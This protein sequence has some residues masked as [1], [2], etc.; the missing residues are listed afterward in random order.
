MTGLYVFLGILFAFWLVGMIAARIHIVYDGAF[1]LY[2]TLL[3]IIKIRIM[4]SDKDLLS[5]PD[6]SPKR[7]ERIRKKLAKAKIKKK[8]KLKKKKAKKKAKEELERKKKLEQEN[9]PRK[10]KPEEKP[11]GKKKLTLKEI[12]YI[13]KLVARVLKIFLWRFKKYL[14]IKA[15]KIRIK[16]ASDDAAKTAYMHGA[17]VAALRTLIAVLEETVNFE[18]VRNKNIGVDVD[19]LSEKL[20]ADIHIVLR[21]RVWHLLALV[22]GAVFT[23]IGYYIKHPMGG[24]AK[25]GHKVGKKQKPK[26]KPRAKAQKK[27]NNE[28][29]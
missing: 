6:L 27:S 23:A 19:F 10:K 5:D 21:I 26:G 4:P 11:K 18:A 24:D 29:K 12:L 9:A 17:I 25:N 7:K 13:V 2:I 3:G 1:R 22:F 28:N 20:E 14:Y 16:V 8:E 15:V